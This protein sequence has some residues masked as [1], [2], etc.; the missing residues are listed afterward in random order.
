ME[1][2]SR[3]SLANPLAYAHIWPNSGP[4]LVVGTSLGQDGSQTELWGGWQG[5]IKGWNSF[6]LSGVLVTQSCLT[7]CHPMDCSPAGP[8]DHGVLWAR[9]LEWVAISFSRGSSWF[10][11]WTWVSCIAGRLLTTWAPREALRLA[12]PKLSQL[13]FCGSSMFLTGTSWCETIRAK[14][15]YRAWPRGW[16][17]WFQSTVP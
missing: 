5:H 12:P 14:G 1:L 2:I 13:I 8:S 10:R 3:L 4:F 17:G 15:Y 6:L 16:G 9:I 11:D 7:L